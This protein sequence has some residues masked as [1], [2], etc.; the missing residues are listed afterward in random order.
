M[1][2]PVPPDAS[3]NHVPA[4][5]TAGIQGLVDNAGRLGLTWGMHLATVNDYNSATNTAFVVVD[6]DTQEVAAK[7]MIG[8]VVQTQRVYVVQVPPGGYFVAGFV[9][10]TAAASTGL[11]IYQARQTLTGSAANVTFSGIP[12]TLR[13]IRVTYCARAD[14][15]VQI[16]TMRMRINGVATANY[17]AEYLQGNNLTAAA[18]AQSGV[19]DGNIGICTGASAAAGIYASGQVEIQQWD[20]A[21][22]INMLPWTFVSQGLGVGTANFFAQSGGG[23][24]NLAGPYTSLVFFS[25]AGN[26]VTGTDIQLEG[27]PTTP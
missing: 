4:V 18:V 11:S 15:A 9:G 5:V 16:Q 24:Y 26:L 14:N 12:T 13:K 20:N 8:T 17:F 22:S 1:T 10:A 6:G 21:G 23:I 25:L 7:S 19:N 2:T 3:V 27:W